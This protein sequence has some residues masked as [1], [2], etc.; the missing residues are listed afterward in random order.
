MDPA[1]VFGMLFGSEAF[2]DYVGT[3]AM[4]TMASLAVDTPG[5]TSSVPT[6]PASTSVAQ[7]MPGQTVPD[8]VNAAEL[9]AKMQ[10]AQDERV[11]Q[12]GEQLKERLEQYEKLGKD[13]FVVWARE[14]AD[15]LA[16]AGELIWDILVLVAASLL[17]R[18]ARSQD[19]GKKTFSAAGP[20]FLWPRLNT[21]LLSSTLRHQAT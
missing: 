9:H 14:E 13:K 2:D 6:G 18:D 10:A 21:G 11:A 20:A 17:L 3:L 12:L 8:A 19:K 16:Q 7:S 15:R 5:A 4:A 1:A